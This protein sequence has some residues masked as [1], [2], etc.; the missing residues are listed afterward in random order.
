MSES[1]PAVNSYGSLVSELFLRF[2]HLS[3]EF[4]EAFGRL[5]NSLFGPLDE[6]E[7]SDHFG[8]AVLSTEAAVV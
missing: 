4:D 6:M 2:V 7:L 1:R 8:L 5:G 3:Y